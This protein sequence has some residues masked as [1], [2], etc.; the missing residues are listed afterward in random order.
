MDIVLNGEN[1]SITQPCTVR[2]LLA[3]RKLADRP[4]AVEVN[5]SLVPKAKHEEYVLNDGDRV[6]IVTL[7]GGG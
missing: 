1:E 3:V 2:E 4:A 5:G 6:E 7:V